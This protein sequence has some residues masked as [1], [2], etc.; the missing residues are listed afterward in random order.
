LPGFA[1]N[2]GKSKEEEKP[3]EVLGWEAEVSP[4]LK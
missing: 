3:Q 4:I 1:D 2:I